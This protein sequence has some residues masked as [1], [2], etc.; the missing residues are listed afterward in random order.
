MVG[1]L[2]PR[3]LLIGTPTRLIDVDPTI[4][5]GVWQAEG[6]PDDDRAGVRSGAEGDGVGT[7]LLGTR[8]LGTGLPGT[9]LLGTGLPGTGLGPDGR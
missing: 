4:R 6:Q 9:G 2:D 3:P 1:T 5:Y 7:G 8:L